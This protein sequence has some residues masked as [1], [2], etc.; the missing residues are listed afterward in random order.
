MTELTA[1]AQWAPLL[2]VLGLVFALGIYIYI[3]RQSSGNA[4]MEELASR[5]HEGAMAFLR[6]EYS[7]LAIFV[8]VVAALLFLALGQTVAIAYVTGALSSVMAGFFGMQAA[9]KANVR[10]TAAAHESGQGKALRVSFFGGAVMGLSVAALG[11][12]G[13][14]VWYYIFGAATIGG[15]AGS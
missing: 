2:G 6:R 5:I 8:V 15:G 12:I 1:L 7:V 9:T 13:I 4:E 11:L 10:T 3:G 14:G